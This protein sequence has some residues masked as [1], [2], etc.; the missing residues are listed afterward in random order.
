VLL[1]SFGSSSS[2]HSAFHR[3]FFS[4]DIFLVVCDIEY[5]LSLL[6][7]LNF[8][9]EVNSALSFQT[10]LFSRF[11]ALG[12]SLQAALFRT[13]INYNVLTLVVLVEGTESFCSN[14]STCLFLLATILH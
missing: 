10:I 2:F 11:S 4:L 8:F 3:W 7:D 6:L 12:A 9:D 5:Q 13:F 1:S 14:F